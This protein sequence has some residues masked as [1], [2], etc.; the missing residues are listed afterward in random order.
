MLTD[1]IRSGA[2]KVRAKPFSGHRD[3]LSSVDSERITGN[4]ELGRSEG[5]FRGLI[6]DAVDAKRRPNS[7]CKDHNK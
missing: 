4:P 1:F 7:T 3:P 5:D 2:P 6:R